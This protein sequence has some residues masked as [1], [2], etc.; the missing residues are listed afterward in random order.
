LLS[1]LIRLHSDRLIDAA[2]ARHAAALQLKG[3]PGAISRHTPPLLPVYARHADAMLPLTRER[4][5]LRCRAHVLRAVTPTRRCCRHVCH[6]PLA[7]RMLM[8]APH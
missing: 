8:R 2:H 4:V 3:L 6:A 7:A 5:T 1:R